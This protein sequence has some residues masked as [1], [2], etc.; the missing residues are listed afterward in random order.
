M[1]RFMKLWMWNIFSDTFWSFCSADISSGIVVWT[2]QTTLMNCSSSNI[3]T[4]HAIILGLWGSLL[5]TL[6]CVWSWRRQWI[7]PL[8]GYREWEPPFHGKEEEVERPPQNVVVVA[9]NSLSTQTASLFPPPPPSA[10]ASHSTPHFPSSSWVSLEELVSSCMMYAV[11]KPCS[12]KGWAEC[13]LEKEGLWM[14]EE[15]CHCT[16]NGVALK[17]GPP[18][19]SEGPEWTKFRGLWVGHISRA[20]V[21]E[22]GR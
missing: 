12:L 11:Q 21:P 5:G 17:C 10:V 1:E 7:Q 22:R 15:T 16:R 14:C 2:V 8:C 20:R 18:S 13:I 3:C 4:L 6:V 9:V 19:H